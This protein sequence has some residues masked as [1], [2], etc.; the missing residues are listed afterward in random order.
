MNFQYDNEL[1]LSNESLSIK[2]SIK[3]Y[4]IKDVIPLKGDNTIKPIL[5]VDLQTLILS[6]EDDII[7]SSMMSEDDILTLTK[8][9][10][11]FN[12]FVLKKL[13]DKI[14]DIKS[15]L[16]PIVL[17]LLSQYGITDIEKLLHGSSSDIEQYIKSLNTCPPNSIIQ[18]TIVS[19]NKLVKKL[20]TLMKTVDSTN[21]LLGVNE[22]VIKALDIG[23]KI[24]ENLPI[25]VAVAGVGIPMNIIT[26]VQQL[27][28]KLEPQINKLSTINGGSLL[29]ITLLKKY[30]QQ[31]IKLLN[32]LD[33]VIQHC[34][35]EIEDKNDLNF[36]TPILI[37]KSLIN[38]TT[39]INEENPSTT[40]TPN[41][42][43]GFTFSIETENTTKSLKRR[44]ALAKNPSGVVLLNG[45]WSFS[46]INQIL[47]DELIFYIQINNLKAD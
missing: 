30:I 41:F 16:I 24:L 11:D 29:I 6:V 33:I 17:Q 5:K 10:K 46:S 21:K 22:D 42:I 47:I 39:T 34:Y 7:S 35:Q 4:K 20:N 8:S 23:L 25:P 31:L 12:Y 9:R 1:K 14:N 36:P 26:G 18:S 38:L 13:S 19:K 28:K 44:R 40:Q 3:D 27:I 32:T 43:N 2:Y 37:S 15:S 45:E